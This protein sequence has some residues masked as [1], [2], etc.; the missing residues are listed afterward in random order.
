[1]LLSQLPFDLAATVLRVLHITAAIV[2]AG[3]AFFQ[4]FALQPVVVT[5]DAAQ[6]AELR[7]RL[8]V[9]WR[10]V[11]W[12]AIAVLLLTGLINFAVYSVP[13]LRQNPHK[14]LYHGLFGLKVLAALGTFHAAALLT[15]P[16]RRGERYRAKGRFWLAFMLVLFAL[17]VVLGAMLR[18][19]RSAS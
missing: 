6:R 19:V 7:E 4:W 12:T 15:L 14:A 18:G 8:A 1:M 16:G 13:A 3:G 9:R 5:L 11:V 10:A 2:A 17:V